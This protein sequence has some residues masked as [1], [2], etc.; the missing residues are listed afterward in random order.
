VS[1]VDS[2]LCLSKFFGMNYL[3]HPEMYPL[4]FLELIKCKGIFLSIPLHS[5]SLKYRLPYWTKNSRRFCSLSSHHYPLS[6]FPLL[7][8]LSLF[9]FFKNYIVGFFLFYSGIST[10]HDLKFCFTY[11]TFITLLL[12][13][14]F[15]YSEI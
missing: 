3:G 6:P 2:I 9:L 1:T 4:L 10:P 14:F 5:W 8:C 13:P 11:W 15:D 7:L 12:I